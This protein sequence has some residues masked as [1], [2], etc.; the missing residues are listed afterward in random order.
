[1]LDPEAIGAALGLGRVAPFVVVALG[2]STS[3]PEPAHAL[4]RPPND[5][6]Q[7]AI[8]WFG[9]AAACLGV[10]AAYARNLLRR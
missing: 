5:H 1:A 7:Y 10:F 9:L 2:P 8:T 4:P 3:A 6:L